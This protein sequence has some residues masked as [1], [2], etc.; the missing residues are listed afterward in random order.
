MVSVFL[1]NAQ[2]EPE[3]RRGEAWLFQPELVIEATDGS[4]VFQ[5][6]PAHKGRS[7]LDAATR[8]ES[9]AN[10]NSHRPKHCARY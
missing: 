1:V 8:F 2:Q 9:T 3:K 7:L 10:S 4:A 5:R 6:R